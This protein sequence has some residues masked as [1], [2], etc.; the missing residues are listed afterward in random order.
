[1]AAF[2]LCVPRFMIAQRPVVALQVIDDATDAPLPEV[3]VSIIGEALE[4]MT[5][6]KGRCVVIARKAGK[7]P[8]L[9]RK[10]GYSPA[11]VMVNVSATDTTRLTVA[12]SSSVQTL[13][14]VTVRDTMNSSSSML[15][16]FHG[17]DASRSCEVE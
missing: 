15:S 16:G 2:A 3:R 6:A 14:T 4:G 10:L 8:M 11:S 9:L 1:M 5:D 17:M 12:M 7:L 13:A